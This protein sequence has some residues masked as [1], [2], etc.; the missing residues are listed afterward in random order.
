MAQHNTCGK[1]AKFTAEVLSNTAIRRCYYRIRLRLDKKGSEC[2]TDVVPGCFA[3]FD[4][5]RVSLPSSEQIPAD[6]ADAAGRQIILRRPFSFSE[7][8]VTHNNPPAVDMEVLYCVLG[9]GTLRMT[10]L[11]P[12]DHLSVIG[13][14]GNGFSV[15][16]G[17]KLAILIAGGM[18]AP[19]LQHLAA[20]LAE[21]HPKMKVVVF[22]GAKSLDDFPFILESGDDGNYDPVEFSRLGD[23]A[24]IATNDGSAGYPGFVTACA[25]EW[26]AQQ[27]CNPDEAIIYACGPEIMLAE[28]SRLA[29]ENQIQCQVSMERMMACGI[30]LCQSCAV[31][32]KSEI[33]DQTEYRLCCKD[34]PVFDSKEVC[35]RI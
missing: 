20:W 10:T 18:G 6:I 24:H 22:A 12:G 31:Q 2:F 16:K 19:P 21:N 5:S 25:A 15:P 11:K 33:E 23:E 9:P 17:K 1:K 30:G 26:L 34:G 7:V 8:T 35:F 27:A 29:A 32:V 4:L 14:L 28:V 3:E 13:P